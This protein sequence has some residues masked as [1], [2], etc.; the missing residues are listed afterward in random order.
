MKDFRSRFGLHT[1]PFTRELPVDH[2]MDLPQYDDA[3]RALVRVADHRMSG[4][5]I[6]PAGTGKTTT[7]RRLIARLPEARYRVHYVKV[8][9]LSKRDMC[10]EIARAVG[11]EPVGSYNML[12]RRLQE[13]FI[14]TAD[15]DAMR[16]VLIL[17]EAHDMRPDVLGMLRILTNFDMDSRLVVSVL[18]SGQGRLSTML[19]R[20]DLDDVARRLGHVATLR[21]LSRDELQHYVEHR[22]TVAGA[23]T[24]P[25][26]AVAIDAIYE[27]G[28]GNLRATNRLALKALQIAH[29]ADH[30]VV[31]APDVVEA[32][33]LL[34]P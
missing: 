11:A 8:T 7:V 20:D 19:R 10:G 33:R 2:C 14:N 34:W 27:I 1:V 12:V 16:P 26:D 29:D 17:D 13:R 32:R 9:S 5:L 21:T 23:T 31:S 6:A 25:M 28:R 24:V 22:L 30:D 4:A 3:V 18:L 15:T